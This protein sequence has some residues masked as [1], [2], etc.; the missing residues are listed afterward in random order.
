MGNIEEA[1]RKLEDDVENNFFN[2]ST[3]YYNLGLIYHSY[4]HVNI[5][6][7]YY[8]KAIDAGGYK[9]LYV[10]AIKNIKVLNEESTL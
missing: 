9:R 3:D 1:R 6:L 2:S 5:A 10:E 4:G 7:D 8:T